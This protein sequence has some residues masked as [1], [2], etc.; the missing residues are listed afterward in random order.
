MTTKLDFVVNSLNHKMYRSHSGNLERFHYWHKNK[1]NDEGDLFIITYMKEY[2]D[3]GL[4]LTASGVQR[5]RFDGI[6]GLS[7]CGRW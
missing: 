3:T 6:P 4:R 5:I 2:A 7:P 1:D